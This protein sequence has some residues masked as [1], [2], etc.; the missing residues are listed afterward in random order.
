MPSQPQ[1][2]VDLVTADEVKAYRGTDKDPGGADLDEKLVPMIT[3]ASQHIA[4]FCARPAIVQ[5]AVT[6]LLD[7][8]GQRILRV[9]V[10]PIK[11][12][13]TL[14]VTENGLLLAG[15]TG[16]NTAADYVVD[17]AQG[18]I[19]RQAGATNSPMLFRA[20]RGFWAPGF[21]NVQVVYTGGFNPVPE[22]LKLVAKYLVWQLI[23]I[24]DQSRIGVSKR[25]EDGG[26]IEF[27]DDLPKWAL[28]ILNLYSMQ[29]RAL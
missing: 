3:A 23:D 6:D 14:T 15:A 19:Y 7:G 26:S 21:Q 9:S 17:L 24:P 20:R 28:E 16:Y 4:R 10:P 18:R 22:D 8:D 1:P 27:E 11:D 5:Q 12:L 29:E 2:L 25:G 13:A